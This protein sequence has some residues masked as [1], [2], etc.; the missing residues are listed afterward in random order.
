MKEMKDKNA[1]KKNKVKRKQK[2]NN[3]YSTNQKIIFKDLLP[4]AE[5]EE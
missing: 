5:A 4:L 1:I 3:T 2:M